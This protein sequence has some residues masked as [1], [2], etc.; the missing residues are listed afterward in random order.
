MYSC[1]IAGY[2]FQPG[3]CSKGRMRAM[4]PTLPLLHLSNFPLKVSLMLCPRM[5]WNPFLDWDANASIEIV[6]FMEL[7]TWICRLL[8]VLWT[9][10]DHLNILSQLQW[11]MPLQPIA[12][13]WRFFQELISLLLVIQLVEELPQRCSANS[14]R[15][16]CQ[17]HVVA[18]SYR[19]GRIWA[20]MAFDMR[21]WKM[22]PLTFCPGSKL[23]KA[24][25]IHHGNHY[26]STYC[27]KVFRICRPHPFFYRT[28]LHLQRNKWRPQKE[29]FSP[30]RDFQ[31]VRC[32]FS[33]GKGGPFPPIPKTT[34]SP[35]KWQFAPSHDQTSSTCQASEIGWV[36]CCCCAGWVRS[37]WLARFT[38]VCIW[39]PEK[40]A[41]NY[42]R[43]WRGWWVW[44]GLDVFGC[45]WMGL[46]GF[47]WMGFE[48]F[49][50]VEQFWTTGWTAQRPN[51]KV[52]LLGKKM[53]SCA[54]TP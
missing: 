15:S 30:S 33:P 2:H 17:C 50:C 19:L 25:A 47:R 23:K 6:P 26:Q 43:I 8:S 40:F 29:A 31:H 16:I 11:M 13:Y 14:V 48:V 9:T 28:S 4:N 37:W 53:L 44:M 27:K 18:F 35:Q 3:W 1:V 21:P 5:C 7:E 36:L 20:L 34:L 54:E 46:D 24:P 42:G 10:V 52:L 38:F 32:L 22:K 39:L 12:I 41:T 49:F 45:V 51:W